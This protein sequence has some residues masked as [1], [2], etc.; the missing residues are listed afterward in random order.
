MKKYLVL[1]SVATA[2]CAAVAAQL[3]RMNSVP[4]QALSNGQRHNSGELANKQRLP[5]RSDYRRPSR[6]RSAC[7]WC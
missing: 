5:R 2:V 6:T 3:T 7:K 1:L 4:A